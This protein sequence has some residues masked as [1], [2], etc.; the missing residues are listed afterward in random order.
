MIWAFISSHLFQR[1]ASFLPW[2]LLFFNHTLE[3]VFSSLSESGFIPTNY[4]Y[5]EDE[6]DVNYGS[7]LF[8]RVASFLPAV[9]EITSKN[10]SAMFSSLSESGFIPTNKH[11]QRGME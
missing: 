11:Q 3:E 9:V 10:A 2:G 4:D 8:Q 6:Y 5:D 1:V 7:H